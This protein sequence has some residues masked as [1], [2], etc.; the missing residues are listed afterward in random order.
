MRDGPHG[1]NVAEIHVLRLTPEAQLHRRVSYAV[2]QS[3]R[4]GPDEHANGGTSQSVSVIR[5]GRFAVG[6]LPSQ[7][8]SKLSVIKDQQPNDK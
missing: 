5:F 4:A 6:L 3:Y 8:L 7:A 2:A 1:L